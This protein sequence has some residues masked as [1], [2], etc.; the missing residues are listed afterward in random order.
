MARWLKEGIDPDI[1]Q[2]ADAQVR[3][4]VAGILKD[5]GER[6]DAAI[7][8]LSSQFDSWLPS[9]TGR[10]NALLAMSKQALNPGISPLASL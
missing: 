10:I 2:Q 6:G 3:A 7:R 5:I 4:T 1:A 9:C 8:E